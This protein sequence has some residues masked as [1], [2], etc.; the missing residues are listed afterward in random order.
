MFN[1]ANQD[2]VTYVWNVVVTGQAGFGQK[3]TKL[4]KAGDLGGRCQSQT[5][6]L[7]WKAD[8]GWPIKLRFS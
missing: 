3:H 8:K 2:Q 1:G 4:S 7:L 5:T 6:E